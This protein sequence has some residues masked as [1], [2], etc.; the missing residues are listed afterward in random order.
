MGFE[1]FKDRYCLGASRWLQRNSSLPFVSY[2]T[3]KSQPKALKN[4]TDVLRCNIE[5]IK[6]RIDRGHAVAI[7]QDGN[8]TNKDMSFDYQG[9]QLLSLS[10]DGAF[11][12]PYL[13]Y[14]AA[15]MQPDD[16]AV[17]HV[18]IER[19]LSNPKWWLKMVSDVGEACNFVLVEH[20]KPVCA[21][22]SAEF[23]TMLQISSHGI[24]SFT[25]N[26]KF[27]WLAEASDENLTEEERLLCLHLIG[28]QNIEP[29]RYMT[30]RDHTIL[31]SAMAQITK[32][33]QEEPN[34]SMS[35]FKSACKLVD[36]N[37]EEPVFFKDHPSAPEQNPI[38]P[39]SGGAS[40]AHHLKLTEPS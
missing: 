16:I 35:D 40:T 19:F 13:L 10:L 32:I 14:K 18:P 20:H 7:V 9:K 25:N 30:D 34:F 6:T 22:A 3:S 21:F 26:A 15:F 12:P 17:K 1:R 24:A 36:L 33:L 39:A 2:K 27:N 11:I 31:L 23:L 4:L 5:A 28:E 29:L 38:T 37:G 8:L